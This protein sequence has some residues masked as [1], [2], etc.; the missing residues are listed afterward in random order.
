MKHATISLA[1]IL[2]SL[3]Y[4]FGQDLIRKWETDSVFLKPESALYDP[5]SKFVYISNINGE[6]LAKD[7]NGFISRI[8]TDGKVDSL[9]WAVGMD[10]PQGMGLWNNKLYVADIDRVAIFDL[11]SG[12]RDKVIPVSDAEFLNDVAIDRKGNVFISDCRKNRIYGLAGDSAFIWLENS[13]LSGPN[14]LYCQNN[15]LFVLNMQTGTIFKVNKQTKKMT[16][17][18]EGIKNCDG[19]VSDGNGGFFVSGAWQGEIFHLNAKGQKQLVLELG[20]DKTITADIEFI[21]QEKLLIIPT[22]HK[23]VI[24][25]EWRGKSK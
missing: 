16:V 22:L 23:K 21:P 8:T 11:L 12:K 6:Y 24:A 2:G 4:A 15:S 1:M 17:F 19:I 7:N 25:F 18:C 5:A 13:L 20:A 14:G 10:N 3:G 9:K